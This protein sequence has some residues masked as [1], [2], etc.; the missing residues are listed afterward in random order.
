MFMFLPST[1]DRKEGIQQYSDNVNL[2]PGDISY[3]QLKVLNNN[4]YF[5]PSD[6]DNSALRK[7]IV[8]IFYSIM[9][10]VPGVSNHNL[11][12]NS[13]AYMSQR[14][15]IDPGFEFSWIDNSYHEAEQKFQLGY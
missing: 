12:R 7:D 13:N 1:L 8:K 3:E 9:R 15:K 10:E 11:V 5:D 2:H 14:G 4:K 6:L